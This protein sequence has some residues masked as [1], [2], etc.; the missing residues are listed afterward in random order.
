MCGGV[1]VIM[2]LLAALAC[3]VAAATAGEANRGP[4]LYALHTDRKERVAEGEACPR[5]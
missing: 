3:M 5:S 2:L 1:Y 4:N